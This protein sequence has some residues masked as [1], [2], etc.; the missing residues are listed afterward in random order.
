MKGIIPSFV[1]R[2]YEK[3]L[4][5]EI[6]NK[7]IPNH[8][9]IILDGNRRGSRILG[10]T[11]E[12]GYELGAKKLEQVLDWAWDLGVRIIT[13]WV[14][15]TENF[16]RPKEQVQT[17]MN[18]AKEKL[19]SI[20]EDPRIHKNKV[21]VNILGRLSLLPDDVKEEIKK[22]EE[23]TSEYEDYVLNVCMA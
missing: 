12:D 20:R 16:S 17:I 3:K 13:V 2:V 4:H 15:S 6:K 1:Y 14:F 22:T 8:V 23:A 19:I 21:K 7:P 10:V 5:S 9:A 11:Y 18:L